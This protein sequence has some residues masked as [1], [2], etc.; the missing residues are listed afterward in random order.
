MGRRLE[1]SLEFVSDRW[2]GFVNQDRWWTGEWLAGPFI[3]FGKE[4]LSIW[5]LSNASY[6]VD[7]WYC[8][9]TGWSLRYGL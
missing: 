9:E 1:L 6:R 3:R 2:K 4:A 8:L 7:G 5:L